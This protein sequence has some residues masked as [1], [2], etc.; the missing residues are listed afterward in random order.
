MKPAPFAYHRPSGL[1]EV[2][3]LL[4]VHGADAKLLAG[5]QSLLPLMNFRLSRPA[6]VIDV[7]RV[8]ALDYEQALDDAREGGQRL[9]L[10]ALTR[11]RRLT[12]PGFERRCRLLSLVGPWIGHPQIRTRGTL[13]GSIA[14][15]DSAAEL[16]GALLALD[17]EVL[18]AS[19][20]GERVIAARDLFVH[21]LTTT[22]EDDE[23]ITGV[24]IP[25]PAGREGCGFAEVAARRGDFAL[26]GAMVRLSAAPAG[27]GS[28]AEARVV[29]IGAG[30]TP[31]R[32][33]A[34]ERPLL[35]GGVTPAS[36]EA[37]EAAVRSG[38]DPTPQQAASREYL[39]RVAGTLAR[40][41]AEQAGA[42]LA[43]RLG[44]DAAGRENGSRH[45][46]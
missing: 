40:R 23:V 17:G 29:L 10:G 21:H 9:V 18:V 12:E 24:R 43:A 44:D 6:H 39:V 19:S 31:L 11:H 42:D 2:L 45:G 8:A 41:A 25:V 30:P 22:L 7:N 36:L 3:E 46:R 15:A 38:V 37:L 32:V 13:G 34:A 27:D 26:A 5:G 35:E 16:P 20:R 1:D 33:E 4:A 14:H 28:L